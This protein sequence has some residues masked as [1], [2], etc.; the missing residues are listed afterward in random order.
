MTE[1]VLLSREGEIA[2]VTLNEPERRN[3][4]SLAMREALF[5]VLDQAMSGDA[6]AIVLTG[7]GGNFCSGGDIKSFDPEAPLVETRDRI[8]RLH[9]VVRLLLTGRK[10][11]VA[12]VDGYAFGAGVSLALACDHVVAATDSRFCAS[13]N[14]VALMADLGLLYTLPL[15]VGMGKA[16]ELLMLGEVIEAAEALAIR[17]VDRLAEPGRVTAAAIERARLFAAAPP[18][19]LAMTKATLARMPAS[20]ETV[21]QMEV[22]GQS[23]LFR[24][25][26]HGE[27]RAAFLEKRPARFQGR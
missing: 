13:F 25:Q 27:G 9:R 6:R 1:P 3:A 18:V 23:A 24:T 7:A 15:R 12:A 4:L 20:L 22:D 10:P 11:V 2:I 21:L 14:R 16:R 5:D 17:L 26:D 8:G 19:A